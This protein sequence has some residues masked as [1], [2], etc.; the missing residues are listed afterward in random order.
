MRILSYTFI[1]L[2]LVNTALAN[3]LSTE[4]LTL[5]HDVRDVVATTKT[6][7]EIGEGKFSLTEAQADYVYE[8][9]KL[10]HEIAVANPDKRKNCDELAKEEKSK[11]ELEDE[12]KKKSKKEDIGLNISLL[13]RTSSSS[14]SERIHGI[15]NDAWSYNAFAKKQVEL[16][17]VNGYV[18]GGHYSAISSYKYA[19]PHIDFDSLSVSEKS[20][21]LTGYIESKYGMKTPDHVFY[22]NLLKDK[23]IADGGKNWKQTLHDVKDKMSFEQKLAFAVKMGEY[24]GDNYDYDRRDGKSDQGQISVAMQLQRGHNGQ[25]TGLCSDTALLSTQMLKEL[26]VPKDKVYIRSYK[27][28]G[29]SH[30]N[31]VVQDPNNP[32]KVYNINYGNVF[33]QEGATGSTALFQDTTQPSTGIQYEIWDADGKSVAKM[34]SAMGSMLAEASNNSSIMDRDMVKSYNLQKVNVSSKYINGNLFHGETTDG[35]VI[36][37]VAVY[38]TLESSSKT[39]QFDVGASAQSYESDREFVKMSGESLYTYLNMKAQTKEPLTKDKPWSQSSAAINLSALSYNYTVEDK[40]SG[41]TEKTGF[42]FQSDYDITLKH[43]RGWASKD[44]RTHYKVGVETRLY[45]SSPAVN[46]RR[47]KLALIHDN[48][49]ISGEVDHTLSN[50]AHLITGAALGINHF[51]KSALLRTD[52]VTKNTTVGAKFQKYLGGA[53]VAWDPNG[54]DYVS[55]Q[56]THFNETTGLDFGLE[57][58]KDLDGPK[59]NSFVFGIKKKF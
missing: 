12:K 28:P 4:I 31:V 19:N 22:N 42:Q 40:D 14:A 6:A 29:G 38:K 52:Y 1:Y 49:K 30:A 23:L 26:G 35:E 16:G 3:P 5:S 2:L 59:S 8:L 44:A 24:G 18:P 43:E 46:E 48:T 51:G 54:R 53:D 33:S 39:Y 21:A 15:N 50:D 17:N 47:A 56:A 55:V 58:Q 37:G 27:T 25:P 32:E 34:P 10:E 13:V 11:K 7:E 9:G 57:Y 45:P 36:T 20:K 41:D